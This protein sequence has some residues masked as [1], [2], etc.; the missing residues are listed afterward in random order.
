MKF[1]IKWMELEKIMSEVT[2][3]QKD[4]HGIYSLISHI[5]HKVK[6]YHATIHRL[7]EPSNAEVSRGG[8]HESHYE[9]EIK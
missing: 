2:Q 1:A 9:G 3:T 4:N 5:S 6:D 8:T 7:K